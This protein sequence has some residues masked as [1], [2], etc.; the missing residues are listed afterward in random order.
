[1][2]RVYLHFLL[3]V[4]LF[5]ISPITF[6]WE[7][8]WDWRGEKIELSRSTT[9]SV[10][11]WKNE[12]FGDINVKGLVLDVESETTFDDE[13]KFGFKLTHTITPAN[14]LVLKYNN[15]ENSGFINKTVTFDNQ[16]YNLGASLKLKMHWF[17]LTWAHNFAA[18]GSKAATKDDDTF[19]FIDGL[20]GVK[21]SKADLSIKGRN[22]ATNSYQEGSWD[23]TFPIPYIG[24][25][26]GVKISPLI[27]LEGSLKY[28]SVNV[29]NGEVKS[30]DAEINAAVKLNQS[31]AKTE[32]EWLLM[33][34][35]RRFSIDG[36]SDNDNINIGYRGPIFG[37]IC[38]F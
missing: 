25:A 24:V 33:L 20:L 8:N 5:A 4:S 37:L 11:G 23:E 36:D 7:R 32:T 34:G 21:V 6:A 22:P 19:G 3:I 28:I 27:W 26:A 17:D 35:Y 16:N 12:L 14:T 31:K 13:T 29:S 10:Y 38:R 18:W 30:V 9:L 1:M 15:F 2:K